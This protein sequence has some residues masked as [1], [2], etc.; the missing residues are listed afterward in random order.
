M[1]MNPKN[2]PDNCYGSVPVSNNRPTLVS[3]SMAESLT[4]MKRRKTPYIKKRA[5]MGTHS[6]EGQGE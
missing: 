6:Q 3:F 5:G 4:K 2:H 1:L